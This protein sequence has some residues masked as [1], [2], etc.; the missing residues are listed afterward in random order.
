[1]SRDFWLVQRLNYSPPDKYDHL[2]SDAPMRRETG[3]V[4]NPFGYGRIGDYEADY[5]GSAEFEFG[6]LN[7]ANNRFAASQQIVQE[8][9]KLQGVLLDFVSTIEKPFDLDAWTKWVQ[10]GADAKD[11]HRFVAHL[12]GTVPEV[13]KVDIWWAIAEDV[14]WAVAS[15]GHIAKLFE[16]LRRGVPTALR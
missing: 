6:A 1:M 16:S 15:E 10:S 3:T 9:H 13:L 12:N 11:S 5:M 14:M 7:D 8:Q 2:A 4:F